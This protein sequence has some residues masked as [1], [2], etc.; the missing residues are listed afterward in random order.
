[1]LIYQVTGNNLE[2]INLHTVAAKSQQVADQ[3]LAIVIQNDGYCFCTAAGNPWQIARLYASKSAADWSGL[4]PVELLNELKNRHPELAADYAR[5]VLAYESR[6]STPIPTGVY[7]DGTGTDYFELVFG[8]VENEQLH[9]DSVNKPDVELISALPIGFSGAA[10]IQFNKMR[11]HSTVAVML[12][13]LARRA[14]KTDRTLYLGIESGA[15]HCF[16]FNAGELELMNLYDIQ[17]AEDVLYF[18]SLLT[19]EKACRL[20]L[21]GSGELLEGAKALL[22]KYYEDIKILDRDER[23]AFDAQLAALPAASLQVLFACLCAS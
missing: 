4:S 20:R 22:A 13:S 21:F 17:Q 5:V 6:R 14:S 18:S 2:S 3:T 15:L 7:R 19:N 11:L 10:A 12:E 1:M 16:V 23:I 9:R 8:R